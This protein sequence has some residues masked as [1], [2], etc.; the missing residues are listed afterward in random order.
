MFNIKECFYFIFK[1]ADFVTF[2]SKN[3]VPNSIPGYSIFKPHPFT[4]KICLFNCQ[5]LW[6]FPVISAYLVKRLI[7]P[8]GCC[9]IFTFDTHDRYPVYKKDNILPVTVTAIRKRE[10]ISY[11][12]NIIIGIC[13][14]DYFYVPFPFFF[15]II[16]GA[17]TSKE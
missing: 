1:I 8:F 13:K 4:C 10:F 2:P 15:L 11:F 9:K 16:S 6:R 3:I 7:N 17:L 12:K 14:I 5:K